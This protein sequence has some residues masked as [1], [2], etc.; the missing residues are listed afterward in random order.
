MLMLRTQFRVMVKVQLLITHS[1]VKFMRS[2]ANELFQVL[3]RYI[4]SLGRDTG[5]QTATGYGC[6]TRCTYKSNLFGALM[7]FYVKIKEKKKQAV[8]Q[9][10]MRQVIYVSTSWNFQEAF[11]WLHE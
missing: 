1:S 6:E 9:R 4:Q 2:C 11:G 3:R 10:C 7:T 5:I 8:A